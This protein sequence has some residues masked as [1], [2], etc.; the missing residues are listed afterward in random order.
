MRPTDN[1]PFDLGF[2]AAD[3]FTTGAG[4]PWRSSAPSL[5]PAGGFED[6][7]ADFPPARPREDGAPP[8]RSSQVAPP[9]TRPTPQARPV[10]PA[11]PAAAAPDY[12]EGERD[13]PAS[14]PVA[15][16]PAYDEPIADSGMGDAVIPRITI[17]A[18]CARPETAALIEKAAADRRMSRAATIVRDGGLEAAVDYYQNQPTPS[19]V[20][21]ET[22]DGAQRLLHLLD[23]LAQVCD[24]GTKVVVV[25]QTNDIAL[26]RELMRRGVSEYL[27]QPLGPL[28]VIRAV[29]ALYADP[30]A[31][32]TG[33]QIAF[34]G[35]K[36]GVGA[37]TLAH[38]FA[39][40]MAEK[41]QSATVLVDLDL[42]F[43]TA[44][45]DFNQDPL[46][47]VLDALSQPDRLDPVLMDRMMVRCAD[48]LSLFAAPASL[49]DDYEFGADAFEEVT[50]KIRGAA[51]FVVLDLPH[52]WNAWSRRV[53]IGS[54]DLVV[55]ATP[56]LASLRN[57]KNII[58]LVKGSRP[59]DAP[60][61]LVLNQ[62]G[63]PGRPEIP[64]KDFG[65]ALGVQPSLVL[66]FDPKPYGQAANNGQML[67]EVAPKS[68]AAEGLE[69]LARLISRR[70]PPPV[71]KTSM[72]SGLFKKK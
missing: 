15:S 64:V 63:V 14:A 21:V 30:A 40:S 39:W 10:Q 11:A 2:D 13:T 52:V 37:S 8:A 72:F 56:D 29:G 45:L 43:G 28:Q 46:Q 35:A 4:D 19:L 65:E 47:G 33:R 18:F 62:V 6:P 55:V 49:D 54:D 25:G 71:Q 44:G 1:D 59:N 12:D 50:Q 67:A 42:A 26:Y 60:P 68:K 16:A 24:P 61:R 32:F 66:P 36:G 27:T 22:L 38:N 58:D 9:T 23:S 7:F 3:E 57:A 48:R 34:V 20:M 31:P 5:T 41:M 70:E 51:P 17:H 69:H 53:L